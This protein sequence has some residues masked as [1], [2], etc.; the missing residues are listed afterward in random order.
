MPEHPIEGLMKTTLDSIRQMIDVNTILGDPVETQDGNVIM[1]VSRVA[2]GFASGGTQWSSDRRR[3]AAQPPAGAGG[4]VAAMPFGGGAGAGVSLNPVGFLVV[5][6][7][8]V[9]FL[10]VTTDAIFDRLIDVVPDLI[11]RL[12][13]PQPKTITVKTQPQVETKRP[14]A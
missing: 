2:F 6:N 9:R 11:A 5:G 14:M 10:P 13:M 1:P 3:D 8:Q 12:A 4:G 7:N